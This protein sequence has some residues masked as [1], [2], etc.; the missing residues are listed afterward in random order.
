MKTSV[1]FRLR[2]ILARSIQK[3]LFVVLLI[4]AAT[5]TL[6][7]QD[8]QSSQKNAP[9][10]TKI[11]P[12]SWWIN[13]TPEVM[14]LLSGR[15]LEATR[16]VC[17]LPSVLVERTQAA[18]GG[19]YLFVWLKIGAETKSGTAVC[20]VTTPTGVTSF[21][22]PLAARGMRLGK[23]QGL[24]Q[25]DVIYLIMPDRFANGDP[26]NDEPAEAR[27]THDRSN[28]RAYHGG[29][30]RGI[31]EHLP[32]LKELG[33]TALWL[34][35]ILKN[36]AAQ[37]YHGYGAVDLYAVDPHLGTVQEYQGLVAEAHKQGM[38]IFFDF[39][40]NHV[41]AKHPWVA[42]PPLPDWFHGTQQR[43]E[44]S[45]V[46]LK[47]EFYGQAEKQSAGHDPFETLVDPHA[48]PALSRNL[49]DGW[50]FGVLPDLN[51]E[52]PL[53]ADYL[54][55]ESI[56]WAETSGLDGYRLDTFPYV[57]RKFWAKWHAQLHAIY[58]QLTTIAEVFH[59][60]PSVTSFFAGGQRRFDGI[61]SGLNTLFDYPMFFA[62]RDVLLRDAP[63]GRIADV[64]RHDSLYVHPDA[65]VTFF[66]NHDV[67]RF[68][69][70]EG[71]T[72]AKQKLAFGLGLTLRGIP[73]IYY[74]DEIG[75]PGGGDPDNRHDFPGGWPGD[76][77]NAF[78]AK[79]RTAEQ[80]EIFDYVQTLLRL[81]R[82]H[83]VLQSGGLWHLSSDN[84]AYVFL[85]ETEEERIV[86]AFNNSAQPRELKIPLGDTPAKGAAGFTPIFGQARAQVRSGEVHISIPAQSLSVFVVD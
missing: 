27:G 11:E 44:S 18:V 35:P 5:G 7:A 2:S 8:E 25:E 54:L 56:W 29:D 70:A 46:G 55:Q 68:A 4:G 10:V 9:A 50:F 43:H 20:R 79:G 83:P 41:G 22:L 37:D 48:P 72:L 75:M 74:G 65:L 14:L 49:T 85:R 17:N 82:E 31:R 76:A 60:D 13:L 63:A 64:L 61:D 81:R 40:P 59:P 47:G 24:S 51:T 39:V 67:P 42:E 21:E 45:S 66:A 71:S 6:F 69:S 30:L 86:V 80:Q 23:F 38:K 62:L 32:Y 84:T 77:K 53:V 36:G 58:P 52:N 34:T 78:T 73:E 26:T 12:P 15:N 33:V 16:V 19:D 3:L 1:S 28:A 57:P